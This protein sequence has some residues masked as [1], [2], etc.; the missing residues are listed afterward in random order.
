MA[1]KS[2]SSTEFEEN[3]HKLRTLSAQLNELA[4]LVLVE[5]MNHTQ[6]AEVLNMSRQNISGAMKRVTALLCDMPSDYVFV[7]EWMPKTLAARVRAELK[8]MKEGAA[9]KNN[10]NICK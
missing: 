7:Q 6:A 4:R 2:M 3:K 10:S 1:V 5:G 9:E 8:T